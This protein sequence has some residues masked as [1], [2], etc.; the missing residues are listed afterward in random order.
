MIT[1]YIDAQLAYLER[2]RKMRVRESEHLSA[3]DFQLFS[4]RFD[5][6]IKRTEE[7]INAKLAKASV[8]C[9]STFPR[10]SMYATG[11]IYRGE[12]LAGVAYCSAW[13][14]DNANSVVATTGPIASLELN[15]ANIVGTIFEAPK[16]AG[17]VFITHLSASEDAYAL[18]SPSA[19]RPA[20]LRHTA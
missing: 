11:S 14:N 12:H 15:A 18:L 5:P 6:L 20:P 10:S 2:L 17:K 9:R 16:V 8:K 1:D 19:F 13:Q 3:V 7:E 4:S